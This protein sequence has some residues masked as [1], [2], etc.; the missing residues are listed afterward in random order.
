MKI[1]ASALAL[2]LAAFLG[3]CVTADKLN[4]VH[5]GMTKGQVTALLGQPDSTSAQANIEYLTYYLAADS[6][7]G[8]DQPYSVRMVDGKVESFGRFSQLFD[9]YN[10]PVTGTPQTGPGLP[11]PYAMAPAGSS[12]LGSELQKL[13]TLRDQGALTEQEFQLAKQKL[14]S[15]PQ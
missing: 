12:D 6:G 8:R 5:I 7:N 3:G 11:A 2:F 10:R 4:D 15:A 9:I 13:K 14:L 1:P